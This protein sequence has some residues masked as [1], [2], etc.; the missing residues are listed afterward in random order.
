[1]M[2]MADMKNLEESKS[3]YK[4]KTGSERESTSKYRNTSIRNSHEM[5]E[6]WRVQEMRVDEFSMQ[7]LR[8]NHAA[9]QK[10]A[11]QIQD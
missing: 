7:K 1:M 11:S 5:K 2:H 10:L 4:K 9:M 6:L 8:E 3:D